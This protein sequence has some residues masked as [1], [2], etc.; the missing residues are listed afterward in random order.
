MELLFFWGLLALRDEER[1]PWVAAL[2]VLGGLTALCRSVFGAYP[3][4]LF[5]ALWRERGLKRAFLFCAL[6]GAGWFVP[7]TIWT[8]RNQ[9]KYG[10][11]V[12]MSAQMGW[13]LWEG[14][15]LDREEVR[16]RPY[17]MDA[18]ALAAG[19]GP[20]AGVERGAHFMA[21]TRAFVRE[22]PGTALEIV[23]GKA[24]LYWRP[25]PYDPHE[26]WKRAALG[27]YYLVLFAL[28]L[29]GARAA[30]ASRAPWGPV[31]ALF[32]YLTAMHAV[33]FTSLRYRLPLEPFLCLLAA[34]GAATLAARRR[35]AA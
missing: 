24:L 33:F 30:L 8:A 15:S 1:S 23:L 7:T 27:A 6:L 28:A 3:A 16:R 17:D 26:G 20:D 14:F 31:W 5:L 13:T 10:K 18:E 4:F 2:G 9:A 21:K 25:F 34:L 35:R 11:L 29:V 32:A 22:N 12:P 19:L